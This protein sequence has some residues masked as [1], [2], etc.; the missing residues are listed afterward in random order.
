MS[1]SNRPKPTEAEGSAHIGMSCASRTLPQTNSSAVWAWPSSHPLSIGIAT[2]DCRPRTADPRY[3]C[4]QDT[5]SRQA[6]DSQ[7][8]RLRGKPL[9]LPQPPPVALQQGSSSTGD[10]VRSAGDARQDSS[11]EG[12]GQGS[13]HNAASKTA[14][15]LKGDAVG[16]SVLVGAQQAQQQVHSPFSCAGSLQVLPSRCRASSCAMAALHDRPTQADLLH[17]DCKLHICKRAVSILQALCGMPDTLSSMQIRPVG[18][19]KP[20]LGVMQAQI[21]PGQHGAKGGMAKL[22]LLK[23][24]LQDKAGQGQGS[25]TPGRRRELQ[26]SCTKNPSLT[27]Q[28]VGSA[29][30]VDDLTDPQQATATAQDVTL[31]QKQAEKHSLHCSTQPH[32]GA[33]WTCASC[34]AGLLS[35][36]GT[37]APPAD[38]AC[39]AQSSLPSPVHR[40]QPPEQ[41]L[42]QPGRAGGAVPGGGCQG[43]GVPGAPLPGI[44]GVPQDHPGCGGAGPPGGHQ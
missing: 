38:T 27:M 25:L 21:K 17:A 29:A 13:L 30:C 41:P 3:D 8:S 2:V 9:N 40:A 34:T 6:G 42:K 1:C 19:Y 28:Q 18:K 37:A 12:A 5:V 36:P 15:A 14:E 44:C 39:H 16:A 22:P 23:E 35:H 43:G 20:H 26:A 31:S 24:T 7:Q 10:S 33:V 4:L 11:A 32:L